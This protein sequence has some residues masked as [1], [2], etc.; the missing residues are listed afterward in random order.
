[1]S[2]TNLCDIKYPYRETPIEIQ[3]ESLQVLGVSPY[4]VNLKEKPSPDY[5]VTVTGYTE[6]TSIPTEEMTFYVDYDLSLLYFHSS[7]TLQWILSSYFGTGSPIVSDDVNRFSSL[8]ISLKS[9]LFSFLVEALSGSRVRM[10]G[11]KFIDSAGNAVNTKKELFIDLGPNGNFE[12]NTIAAGYSKKILIGVD[13][14]LSQIAIVEGVAAPKRDGAR[15]PTFSS[16]F[17]PVAIITVVESGGSV[18]D[19]VQSDIIPVR[20]FLI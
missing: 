2:Y 4:T 3:D 11:G 18:V 12:L 20:N 7:R 17:R 8:L 6:V 13:V 5:P 19:I 16:T 10:Y 15:I 14:S 9:A 1:M